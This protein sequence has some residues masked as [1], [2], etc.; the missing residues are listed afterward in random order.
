MHKGSFHIYLKQ[1]TE[2]F[3]LFSSSKL[4][5]LAPSIVNRSVKR[6]LGK[7]RRDPVCHELT[8]WALTKV[9]FQQLCVPPVQLDCKSSAACQWLHN[10]EQRAAGWSHRDGLLCHRIFNFK[11]QVLTTLSFSVVFNKR[12]N[13]ITLPLIFFLFSLLSVFL[14]DAHTIFVS[15]NKL[16]FC[17]YWGRFICEVLLL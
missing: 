17:K 6:R 14:L 8:A 11:R 10:P 4:V 2:K 7:S 3:K 9:S 15:F 5:S 12:H 1:M 16:S 13:F